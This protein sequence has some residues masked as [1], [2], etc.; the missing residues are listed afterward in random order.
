[1]PLLTRTWI[2]QEISLA[3][4]P[5][6]LY[7]QYTF[8]WFGLGVAAEWMIHR[9]YERAEY[10]GAFIRGIMN[11]SIICAVK[12]GSRE[13]DKTLMSAVHFDC[14]EPRDKIFG[15]LGLV[16][17]PEQRL[18]QRPDY[19]RPVEHVFTGA[20]RAAIHACR[21]LWLLSTVTVIRPD[22]QATGMYD[23]PSWVPQFAAEWHKGPKGIGNFSHRGCDDMQPLQIDE[24]TAHNILRVQGVHVGTV[25]YMN[26]PLE[27]EIFSGIVLLAGYFHQILL[28][29]VER[30]AL[31]SS[32]DKSF[33]ILY[34]AL[35]QWDDYHHLLERDMYS[36][37]LAFLYECQ[38]NLPDWHSSRVPI[39]PHE[40]KN[41]SSSAFF[42]DHLKI[43]AVKRTFFV[44]CD[45]QAGQ[46]TSRVQAGDQVCI[47]FGSELPF[48]LQK[49]AGHFV[50][51]GTARLTEVM[52]VCGTR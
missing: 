19:T 32:S 7:G 21:R 43:N 11:A 14:S 51:I 5:I 20:T 12:R 33:S 16:P 44:T 42:Q 6:Y 18:L 35:A 25:A 13:M 34:K 23:L 28:H 4:D 46:A 41:Q 26:A 1:M 3:K 47:L 40:A 52:D 49:V 50:L 10:C 15:L 39:I 36:A 31:P 8:P 9:S 45:G 24:R 22:A 38:Q 37:F 48:V 29:I 27:A 17:E 30:N 2:V